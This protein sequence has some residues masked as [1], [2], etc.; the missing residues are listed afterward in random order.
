MK[1]HHILFTALLFAPLVRAELFEVRNSA[2]S[3]RF[4]PGNGAHTI[5]AN[6]D[7][8]PDLEV[9]SGEG[10]MHL[11]NT[12]ARTILPEPSRAP[13]NTAEPITWAE[14]CGDVADV[15]LD[16]DLDI[17]RQC[18][19]RYNNGAE[20]RWR[21]QV[22]KN[23]G[24]GT[25]TEGW[26]WSLDNPGQS[27][28][29]V[30]ESLSLGDF[31]DD[32]DADML[33]SNTAGVVIRWNSGHGTGVFDTTLTLTSGYELYNSAVAD[34][35][36]DGLL[37]IL[38]FVNDSTA[39]TPRLV[40]YTNGGTNG[41]QPGVFV[42]TILV[43]FSYG[44]SYQLKAADV[45]IDGRMDFLLRRTGVT[46][47]N[48]S[49]YRN[50][51]SGFSG[52]NTLYS[53][54]TVRCFNMDLADV[55]EDGLH[56]LILTVDDSSPQGS[57]YTYPGTSPGSFGGAD[58][59]ANSYLESEGYLPRGLCTGDADGDGRR[60]RVAHGVAGV[61]EQ[62]LCRHRIL[63]ATGTSGGPDRDHADRTRH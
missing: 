57:I 59:I 5:M 23:N 46:S 22:L 32:G 12:P 26:T 55:N 2:D 17:V 4:L 48:V 44:I 27:A 37:D 40:L 47:G 15:D 3:A 31:D 16:G 18:R 62:V 25:F 43:S 56:D 6:L 58:Y 28:L 61:F 53:S 41:G 1:L 21:I 39:S 38:A 36:N 11:S 10:M 49:W 51:G 54:S 63:Y 24:S 19:L 50:T 60:G 9:Y 20:P 42:S 34:F 30:G 52:A 7:A 45:N 33:V 8:D 29:P 35:D 13:Y 14:N